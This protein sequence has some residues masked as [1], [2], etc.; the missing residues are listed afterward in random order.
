MLYDKEVCMGH[1]KNVCCKTLTVNW[2]RSITDWPSWL[3]FVSCFD[4]D[5]IGREMYS[6]G[7]TPGKV[8]SLNSKNAITFILCT[9]QLI[10]L[11]VFF[12][13]NVYQLLNLWF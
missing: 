8:C 9:I 2:E 12:Q 10:G 6:T 4:E 7:I 13:T 1:D 3:E 11:I 5:V